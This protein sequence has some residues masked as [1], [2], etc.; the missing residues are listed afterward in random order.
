MHDF[1]YENALQIVM[2]KMAAILFQLKFVKCWR[3]LVHNA[4]SHFLSCWNS[5]LQTEIAII[6]HI[7]AGWCIGVSVNWVIIGGG[8]N[9]VSCTTTSHYLNHWCLIVKW[10]PRNILQM[11]S[12]KW[13]PFCLVLC[14]LLFRFSFKVLQLQHVC[15]IYMHVLFAA[16]SVMYKYAFIQ[17]YAIYS[18]RFVIFYYPARQRLK[19]LI[20]LI[21]VLFIGHILK[22]Q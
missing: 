6:Y 15:H 11:S 17:I 2:C 20:Y 16:L 21:R 18:Y 14:V 4:G 8:N 12:A 10:A 13:C 7:E 5:I 22:G 3:S 9:L 19:Y 1:L